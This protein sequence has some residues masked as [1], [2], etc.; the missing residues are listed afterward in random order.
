MASQPDGQQLQHQGAG[1]VFRV[2]CMACI[3]LAG[4]IGAGLPFLVSS[5]YP[6]LLGLLNA[7]AA[8]VFLSAAL[9]HLLVSCGACEAEAETIA[10]R[11]RLR[12][13]QDDAEGNPGLQRWSELDDQRYAF[14]WAPAFCVVGFLLLLVVGELARSLVRSTRYLRPLFLSSPPPLT[15]F[16]VLLGTVHVGG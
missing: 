11:M 9:V 12:V 14:P 6:R 13:W 5:R 3:F 7:A 10:K 15:L 16:G 4:L 8:G 2:V 1:W